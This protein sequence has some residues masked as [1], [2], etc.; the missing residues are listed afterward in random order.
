LIPDTPFNNCGKALSSILNVLRNPHGSTYRCV[1]DIIPV[2]KSV[3]TNIAPKW[4]ADDPIRMQ[5]LGVYRALIDILPRLASLDLDSACRIQV[6]SQARDLA[7]TASSHAITLKQLDHAV[8]L[9]ESGRAVFWAQHLRLRTSF[10]SLDCDIGKELRDISRRLEVTANPTF[11]SDLD[12]NLARARI[13]RIMAER[14]HLGTRFDALVKQVQSQPGMSNFLRNLDYQALSPA[15][16]RGP[17]VILQTSWLCV[18]P[19]PYQTPQIAFLPEA[20]DQWIRNSFQVLRESARTNRTRLNIKVSSLRQAAH[21][22]ADYGIL[23][24]IWT[25][26][27]KPL[28]DILGWPVSRFFLLAE[29]SD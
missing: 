8:E 14:R 29:T 23:T 7:T 17:V 3:E 13:E 20:T 27:V 28:L 4:M 24:E 26:I 12:S 9:L 19:S 11:P 6:L 25:R 2:L 16:T 21:C 5:C 22:G 15:A 10:D 1:V 18:I